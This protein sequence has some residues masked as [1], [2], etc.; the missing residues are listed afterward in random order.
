M[1][2]KTVKVKS[3]GKMDRGMMAIG[4]TETSMDKASFM[5]VMT[6]FILDNGK[7]ISYMDMENFLGLMER[8]IRVSTSKT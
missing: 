2:R 1:D 7:T 8:N 5:D 3:F 6:E 4:P